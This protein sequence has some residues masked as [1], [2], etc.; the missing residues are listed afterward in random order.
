MNDRS[1]IVLPGAALIL[2][3]QLPSVAVAQVSSAASAASQPPK[4]DAKVIDPTFFVAIGVALIVGFFIGRLSV[5][6]RVAA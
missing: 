4:D 1:R 5:Q 2:A 6:R 3:S